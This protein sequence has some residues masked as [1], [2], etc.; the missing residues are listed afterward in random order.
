MTQASR[1]AGDHRTNFPTSDAGPYD[2]DLWAEIYKALFSP[3][4]NDQG[5]LIRYLNELEVTLNAAGPPPVF[6]VATGAGM[7]NGHF[8]H[9]DAVVDFTIPAPA[10]ANAPLAFNGKQLISKSN[11]RGTSG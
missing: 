11:D 7:V 10:L 5:P 3:G 1:P 8:F 4:D 6:R 2:A 9:N